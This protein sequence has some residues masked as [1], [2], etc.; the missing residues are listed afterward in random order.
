MP[1]SSVCEFFIKNNLI[2]RRNARIKPGMKYTTITAGKKTNRKVVEEKT[3]Y[4]FT[5][6]LYFAKGD[7]TT[8]ADFIPPC[9][10]YHIQDI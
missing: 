3:I 7:Y 6:I 4:V 5:T 8:L 2:L 9:I 1:V 10:P